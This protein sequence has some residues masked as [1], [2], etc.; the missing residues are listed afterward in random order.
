ME[1]KYE[2]AQNG[3]YDEAFLRR[4]A[5]QIGTALR[6]REDDKDK[7]SSNIPS[8]EE[9][10]EDLYRSLVFDEP[11]IDHISNLPVV[12]SALARQLLS[13]SSTT[14]SYALSN[15]LLNG[16][17]YLCNQ[18]TTPVVAKLENENESNTSI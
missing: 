2:K 12:A 7:Q 4:F 9:S 14:S 8:I 5:A 1:G 11:S 10:I 6:E 15:R 3:D 13:S 18:N 16:V 17:I